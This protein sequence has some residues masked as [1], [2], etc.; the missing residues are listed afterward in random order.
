MPG[1]AWVLKLLA[2]CSFCIPE[3]QRLKFVLGTTLYFPF[4]L[5]GDTLVNSFSY[6]NK[7]H[8]PTFFRGGQ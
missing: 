1:G 2:N 5:A 4:F 7:A 3:F 8:I 6:P